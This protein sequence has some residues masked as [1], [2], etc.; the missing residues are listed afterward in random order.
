MEDV[1]VLVVDDEPLIVEVVKGLLFKI[2]G[3]CKEKIFIAD[4]TAEALDIYEKNQEKIRLA[5][6]DI[7]MPG[8]DGFHCH[9]ELVKIN[10][11]LAVVFNSGYLCDQYLQRTEL[12]ERACFL[13]KPFEAEELK[14]AVLELF[15]K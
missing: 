12:A 1:W 3:F 8:S 6:I 15:P 7:I 2:L 10:D 14:K 5:I 11:D 4:S 13:A 9:E